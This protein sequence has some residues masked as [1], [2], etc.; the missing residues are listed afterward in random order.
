MVF[1]VIWLERIKKGQLWGGESFCL[2][3]FGAILP[4]EAKPG[5]EPPRVVALTKE[6]WKE[7]LRSY[8]LDA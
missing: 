7:T 3:W 4:T 1:L 2:V 5:H 8:I 6:V